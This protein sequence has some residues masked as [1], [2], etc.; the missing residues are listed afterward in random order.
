MGNLLSHVQFLDFSEALGFQIEEIMAALDNFTNQAMNAATIILA[1]G[2][3]TITGNTTGST[4]A[5]V[6]RFI[7]LCRRDLSWDKKNILEVYAS[8]TRRAAPDEDMFIR[9]GDR[10]LPDPGFGFHTRNDGIYGHAGDGAAFTE[11]KLQDL[12]PGAFGTEAIYKATLIPG[13]RVEFYIDGVLAGIITTNLP[14][15]IDGEYC[16]FSAYVG[17]GGAAAHAMEFSGFRF[18]QGE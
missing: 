3:C 8:W 10:A 14:S 5:W 7:M 15:G 17:P 4:A 1:D 16:P 13:T 11:L 2:L 6:Q 9:R 12:G 18:Y